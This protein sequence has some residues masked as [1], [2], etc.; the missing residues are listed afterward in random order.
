[1]PVHW[2]F[3]PKMRCT[4]QSGLRRPSTEWRGLKYDLAQNEDLGYGHRARVA[5]CLSSRRR[6][7]FWEEA[8]FM[9]YSLD[10][11][12]RSHSLDHRML[13]GKVDA[14]PFWTVL[15]KIKVAFPQ[16]IRIFRPVR[17][18]KGIVPRYDW[19]KATKPSMFVAKRL[20]YIKAKFKRISINH[21]SE[22]FRLPDWVKACLALMRSERH[23][24]EYAKEGICW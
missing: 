14:R 16:A 9:P 19:L 22:I 23:F 20:C 17:M 12:R 21:G 24:G 15:P 3:P 6:W 5:S 18:T 10:G 1:M 8:Y 2:T 4:N 11:L 13:C 7:H